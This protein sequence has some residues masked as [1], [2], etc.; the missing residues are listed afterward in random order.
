MEKVNIYIKT[1]PAGE[2]NLGEIDKDDLIDE[3]GFVE[4]NGVLSYSD[5]DLA[6]EL[7]SMSYEFDD[8]G[9]YNGVRAEWMD[10]N[11]SK[12]DCIKA[13]FKNNVNMNL[14]FDVEKINVV[15]EH[16]GYEFEP[17]KYYLQKSAPTKISVDFDL[18]V[19][20]K[21]FDP[22]KLKIVIDVFDFPYEDTYSEID[23]YPI[24]NT[25][26]YDGKDYDGEYLDSMVDRGYENEVFVFKTDEDGGIED[27]I[28]DHEKI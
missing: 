5:T 15:I 2:Y 23:A 10:C 28:F 20:V 22:S 1:E 17:N 14:D 9:H 18:D 3:Y 11:I 8:L 4:N 25:F 27:T 26:E 19:D 24:I 16:H 7:L 21:D 12:E 6:E 13:W